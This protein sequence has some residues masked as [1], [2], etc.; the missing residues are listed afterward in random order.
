ML[1][2]EMSRICTFCV[3]VI[4]THVGVHWLPWLP[5]PFL[6]NSFHIFGLGPCIER[7]SLSWCLKPVRASWMLIK[8]LL[9]LGSSANVSPGRHGERNVSP[10]PPPACAGGCCPF[11]NPPVRFRGETALHKAASSC[12]RSICHYLVEAGASLMKT[13]LQVRLT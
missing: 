1:M 9:P 2:L 6:Y 13:D 5:R 3:C 11:S 12:Q 8:P 7:G 4:A 10:V